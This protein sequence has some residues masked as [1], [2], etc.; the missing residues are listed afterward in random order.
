MAS[1]KLVITAE[2]VEEFAHTLQVI[3]QGGKASSLV[4][5]QKGVTLDVMSDTKV[6]PTAVETP[7]TVAP[8]AVETPPTVTPPAVETPPTVAPPAATEAPAGECPVVTLENCETLP[9]KV[10]IEYLERTPEVGV[11]PTKVV[12]PFFQSYIV[13]RIKRYLEQQ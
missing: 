9:Q 4:E 8:P 2:T 10:L 3:S 1:I 6:T 11:D 12:N 13:A 7:P 5:L